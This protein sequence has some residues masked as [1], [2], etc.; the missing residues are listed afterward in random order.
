VRTTFG[1]FG[2]HL[3]L[4]V[5]GGELDAIV[6]FQIFGGGGYPVNPTPEM[7]SEIT[8]SFPNDAV[9]VDITSCN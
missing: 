8:G 1:Q 6:W 2:D 7:T 4:Y 3:V 9:L 5:P